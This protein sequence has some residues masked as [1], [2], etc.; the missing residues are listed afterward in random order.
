M[1]NLPGPPPRSLRPIKPTDAAESIGIIAIAENEILTESPLRKP[2][3]SDRWSL[4]YLESIFESAR[5]SIVVTNGFDHIFNRLNE[6]FKDDPLWQYK[7]VVQE[8]L[9][10]NRVNVTISWFG[11]QRGS[12]NR[13]S[14]NSRHFY[15]INLSTFVRDIRSFTGND[16]IEKMLEFGI[17]LRNF[18]AKNGIKP[19][20]TGAGIAGQLLR[21]PRFYPNPRRRVPTFINEKARPWLP[22]N[23]Y[24][25]FVNENESVAAAEYIDQSAA[26]HYAVRTTP[27]PDAD[28]TYGRGFTR[29][30]DRPWLFP[31]QRG[32]KRV[33]GQ[34][35]LLF[36]RLQVPYISPNKHRYV[37]PILKGSGSKLCYLWTNEIEYIEKFGAKIEYIIAAYTSSTRDSGLALYAKWAQEMSS[38]HK[39]TKQLLL[40]SYGILATR[41]RRTRVVHRKG[42]G[43]NIQLPVGPHFIEGNAG[44]VHDYLPNGVTHVLQR[45]LIESYVRL[46]S[47]ELAAEIDKSGGDTISI[48]GDGIFAKIEPGKQLELPD[49]WRLKRSVHNLSFESAQR[50]RSDEITR[51]PGTPR[52]FR[53]YEQANAA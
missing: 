32:Y 10:D 53:E 41:P 29:A 9:G 7:A 14:R 38:E 52:F 23:H 24:D 8:M 16:E 20:S 44:K 39:W 43:E 15:P 33:L 22:G 12:H 13:G 25:L 36:V 49:P 51:L 11:W 17:Q 1:L 35:G 48:Y 6:A 47:L 3:I 40:T 28:N 21:H 5:Q 26:H 4:E 50:L 45:G 18:C 27:M 2:R 31:G 37:L 46:L 34:F 30:G 19:R 42:N